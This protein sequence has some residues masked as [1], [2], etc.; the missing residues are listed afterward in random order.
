MYQRRK[1]KQIIIN[2]E[3]FTAFFI[4]KVKECSQEDNL[5]PHSAFTYLV[6]TYYCYSKNYINPTQMIP[7][8]Q[9][10]DN[11]CSFILSELSYFEF[12][13]DEYFNLIISYYNGQ[14]N[15]CALDNVFLSDLCC[16]I[17]NDLQRIRNLIAK[18]KD[19]VNILGYQSF[20]DANLLFEVVDELKLKRY[21][22]DF[23]YLNVFKYGIIEGKR[24]E[25][26][27]KKHSDKSTSLAL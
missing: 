15:I 8:Q 4:S 3:T 6:N 7:Y 1:C 26:A 2:Q 10:Y 20:S 9:Y 17:K 18:A 19:A 27:R 16:A 5:S 23:L 24:A 12:I 21:S 25:R 14:I 22:D 11:F 13:P